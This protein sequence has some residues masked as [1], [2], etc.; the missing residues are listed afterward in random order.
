MIPILFIIP[1]FSLLSF[2]ILIFL[3]AAIFGFLFL[4]LRKNADS[5]IQIKKDLI[6]YYFFIL[7]I[8]TLLY[9]FGPFPVR[10]YGVAIACGFLVAILVGRPLF[11][12]SNINPDA[13][14]DIVVYIIMGVIIGARLFYIIFYDLGYF[15]NNPWKIV[16]VWEGG[17]VLYGGLIGGALAGIYKMKKMKLNL[18]KTL[19]VFGVIIPLGIIFGRFGCLGYGCC[20]AK[21]APEWFPFKISFPATGHALTGHTPAFSEHLHQGL[22]AVG[23]KFSLPVYP[24][25]I[26]SSLNGL[27]LFIVL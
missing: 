4:L 21:I 15:I 7:I 23:D 12:K 20:F 27:L 3:L 16:A 6:G 18:L 5:V 1:K 10:T 22:V 2:I 19:D 25:Q 14:F 17:L 13:I 8:L 9:F 26:I 24:S 11:R